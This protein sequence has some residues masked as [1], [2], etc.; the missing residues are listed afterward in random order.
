[1][2]DCRPLIDYE[3]IQILCYEKY[4]ISLHIKDLERRLSMCC[5]FCGGYHGSLFCEEQ[6][7]VK[8]KKQKVVDIDYNTQLQNILDDFLVSNQV[9]LEKFNLQCGDLVEKSHESQRKFVQ[10]ETE[11]HEVV[12]EE[13]PKVRS[14]DIFLKSG[15]MEVKEI[16]RV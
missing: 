5:D 3:E 14:V 10:M 2:W 9:S 12:V 11:C 4:Q 1:M 6:Y 8:E 13:N 7:I 16:T 15:P